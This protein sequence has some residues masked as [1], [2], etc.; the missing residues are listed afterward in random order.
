MNKADRIRL[1]HM[2]DAA[3]EAR[4]FASGVTRDSLE[5][6]RM[7]ALAIIKDV[8]IIG[9]AASR[10]SSDAQIKHSQIPWQAIIAMRNRLV[11]A[12]FEID[13]DQVWAVI[14]DDLPWLITE[15]KKILQAEEEED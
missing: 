15:L 5:D 8:E 4:Q 1:Q 11:H 13:Y 10:I 14:V 3:Q 12:Y 7:L 6:D 2:L 9:E